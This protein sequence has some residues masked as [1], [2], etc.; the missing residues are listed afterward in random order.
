MTWSAR[1]SSAGGIVSPSARA[2]LRMMTSSKVVGCSRGLSVGGEQ[3]GQ[4]RDDDGDN[5]GAATASSRAA[6]RS[7]HG[8]ARSQ[9]AASSPVPPPEP[10]GAGNGNRNVNAC[11]VGP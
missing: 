3:R 6:R 4:H 9:N 1:A 7:P 5:G 8:V 2:A 11:G 10:S